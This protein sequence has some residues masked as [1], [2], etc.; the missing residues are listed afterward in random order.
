MSNFMWDT[1][2][3]VFDGDGDLLEIVEVDF[4]MSRPEIE[5]YIESVL[6]ACGLPY[7]WKPS[8]GGA[9]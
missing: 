2:V 9:K 1:S 8:D 4:R 5:G 3:E 7:D 6:R